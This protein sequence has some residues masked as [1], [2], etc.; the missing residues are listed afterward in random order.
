[1]EVVL[2]YT[3]DGYVGTLSVN[4]TMHF[5]NMWFVLHK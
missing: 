2:R 5:E 4:F 3:N 1:M